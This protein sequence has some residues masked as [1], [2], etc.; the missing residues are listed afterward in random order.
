MMV[1]DVQM[2]LSTGPE[3]I[4]EDVHALGVDA[5]FLDDDTCA[6]N[7]F[8]SVTLLVDLAEASPRSYDGEG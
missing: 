5:I 4:E 2:G 7:D 6:A 1:W 8:A 3:V